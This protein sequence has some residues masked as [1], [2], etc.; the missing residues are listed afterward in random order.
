[1]PCIRVRTSTLTV[2]SVNLGLSRATVD[3][4][5]DR[6]GER[7]GVGIGGDHRRMQRN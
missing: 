6:G 4:P 7:F 3:H 2:A 5:D 1:M